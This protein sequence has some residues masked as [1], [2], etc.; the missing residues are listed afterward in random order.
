M[1]LFVDVHVLQTVPP[2]NLNRDDTGSPKTAMYGGV[3]RARVSSQA[4][5]RAIRT[6]FSS[7]LGG[8]DMG[9][10]SK[11]VVALIAAEITRQEPELES[12]SVGLAEEVLVAG[13]V[14]ASKPKGAKA[15]DGSVAEVGY[16]LFLSNQQ[17]ETLAAAAVAFTTNK[18]KVLDK[19]KVKSIFKGKNSIDLALF[20]RM[21]ADVTDLNVDAAAQVAHAISVQAVAPE[22]DYFT[23]MDEAKDVS[24]G[25][26][27][28]AAIIGTVEFNSSTLYRYASVDLSGLHRNLGEGAP[29]SRA[30]SAFVQ[31]FVRSMP[32]GKQ[33]TFGNRTLP[34]A[35]VVSIR[36]DQPVS[37]VGAF[38]DA[39]QSP[40]GVVKEA[41]ERLA[42]YSDDTRSAFG[43]APLATWVVGV[44][45]RTSS[46]DAIGERSTF[47]DLLAGLESYVDEHVAEQQ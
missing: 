12:Q 1:T 34:D 41:C 23:G 24:K 10:R 6:D 30:V 31:S 16:L 15:G 35:V 28:G 26:D 44:G 37:L 14:K 7:Y 8:A 3:R 4:W 11:R 47:P 29:T 22:F 33:N 36:D 21:V 32:T 19:A 43:N 2:S 27:A 5:K 42:Q 38:E 18:A 25:D 46:L 40:V 9:T 13:G 45:E 39:V 20:G 17:I